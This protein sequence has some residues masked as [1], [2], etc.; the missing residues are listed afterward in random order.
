MKGKSKLWEKLQKDVLWKIWQSALDKWRWI[1]LDRLLRFYRVHI[2]L[3]IIA[4]E[5]FFGDKKDWKVKKADK[6]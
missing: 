3:E 2:K 1:Q 5:S 4:E 6:W